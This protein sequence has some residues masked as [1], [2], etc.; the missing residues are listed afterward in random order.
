MTVDRSEI[1]YFKKFER[2][3]VLQNRFSQNNARGRE[4]IIFTDKIK[5]KMFKGFLFGNFYTSRCVY[6]AID[7]YDFCCK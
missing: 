1:L 6:A 3:Q 7:V 5:F 2:C 4:N